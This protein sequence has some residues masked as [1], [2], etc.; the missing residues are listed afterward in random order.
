MVKNNWSQLKQIKLKNS[1]MKKIKNK[2][3]IR[4]KKTKKSKKKF[5]GQWVWKLKWKK[6]IKILNNKLK[7][8]HNQKN[9]NLII[10]TFN[11]KM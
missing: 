11:L 7:I 2:K 10:S 1:R 9:W 3:K 5:I 4:N 6:L 8:N